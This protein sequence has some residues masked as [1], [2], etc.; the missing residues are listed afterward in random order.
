MKSENQRCYRITDSELSVYVDKICGIII[1][2][3]PSVEEY[4][5]T[6]QDIS[7][8]KELNDT[9][10]WLP[11]DSAVRTDVSLLVKAKNDMKEA[12]MKTIK[13]M[14]QRVALK[15][16]DKSQEYQQLGSQMLSIMSQIE[17]LSSARTVHTMMTEYLQSLIDV[18]LTQKMLDDFAILINKF[19]ANKNERIKAEKT[20][21]E[22]SAE[23]A[24]MGNKLYAKL[25]RVCST[26]Q[27]AV[28]HKA[29]LYAM[30]KYH[31]R[32]RQNSENDNDELAS[33]LSTN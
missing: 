32:K 8:M 12:I 31:K 21:L 14:S 18:G 10:K 28:P 24:A 19:E 26:A 29:K 16:G 27:V 23:R 22:K 25:K 2:D 7:E 1:E 15:W 20:R 5:I 30:P 3:L 13:S 17:L 33:E 11:L 9:F 6:E 4:G